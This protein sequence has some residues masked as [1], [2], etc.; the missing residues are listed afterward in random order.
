MSGS[1][2]DLFL[3][4]GIQADLE[5]VCMVNLV[6]D[7]IQAGRCSILVNVAGIYELFRIRSTSLL[8]DRVA[9]YPGGTRHAPRTSD[10]FR[11]QYS[12]AARYLTI[13]LRNRDVPAFLL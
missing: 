13:K 8:L 7:A 3:P 11:T 6:E 4:S 5:K 12:A 10:V 1:V 2:Y 9:G